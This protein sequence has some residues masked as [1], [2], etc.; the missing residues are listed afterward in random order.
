MSEDDA[1]AALA[2]APAD[3]PNASGNADRMPPLA[4][5]AAGSLHIEL[6]AAF[7]G[8]GTESFSSWAR[9]FEV[10]VQAMTPQGTDMMNML[11][12]VLPTRLSDAA[13]LYWDSLP[14]SVK[15]SYNTVKDRLRH[16]FGLQHSLPFF[17]THV[18]ARPAR[19]VKV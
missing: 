13:F 18:N 6:P 19:L 8:D 7:K 14:N 1:G 10:A 4:P 17:Q 15:T 16:V 3:P 5:S 2:D 12:S 9:R 11:A